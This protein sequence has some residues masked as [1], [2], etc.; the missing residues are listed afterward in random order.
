MN[1]IC[2]QS[3]SINYRFD[4]TCNRNISNNVM[5]NVYANVLCII[6]LLYDYDSNLY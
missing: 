2:N 1:Q 3:C 4:E 6:S 5:Y